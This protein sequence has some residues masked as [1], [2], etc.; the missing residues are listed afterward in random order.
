GEYFRRNLHDS[1]GF[2]TLAEELEHIEAYLAIERARFGEKLKVEYD[3]EPGVEKYLV[4]GL[5]LQPLVENAIKH[6]LLPKREGGVV[7]ICAR[8]IGNGTLELTVADNGIGLETDPFLPQPAEQEGKR[9]LSGIGLS[10]VRGRLQSIY[11]SP[12]G[13][14][15]ESKKGTGT[16]CTITLPVGGKMYAES[17]HSG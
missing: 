14:V 4:P 16:T 13:I 2:V 12:Y 17:V 3:I 5:V 15:I 11:G 7:S 6:G 8:R 10:N 9:R 1:G